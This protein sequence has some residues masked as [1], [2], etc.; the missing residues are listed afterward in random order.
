[1]ATLRKGTPEW[2]TNLRNNLM[3]PTQYDHT[4]VDFCSEVYVHLQHAL[5]HYHP[6]FEGYV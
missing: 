1:M 2:M 5:S 6:L 3:P 4:F